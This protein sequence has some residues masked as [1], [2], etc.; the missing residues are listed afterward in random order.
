MT[1]GQVAKIHCP[2][3]LNQG[4]NID[5]YSYKGAGWVSTDEDLTY[6]ITVVECSATP[7]SMIENLA[8]LTPN[9][10]MYITLDGLGRNLALSVDHADKYKPR[11]TGV[12]NVKVDT[13]TG[14]NSGN[15]DQQWY[16]DDADRTIHSVGH[17]GC[18]LLEG[19]NKNVICYKNMKM[20][21]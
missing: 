4:G 2:A 12:Y 7:E 13:F 19:F 11:K 10:C 16:W 3:K 21:Q 5:T 8:A 1:A 9:K 14:L 18:V 17:P 6:E 20:P 15:K